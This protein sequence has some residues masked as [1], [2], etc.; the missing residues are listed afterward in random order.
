MDHLKPIQKGRRR[1]LSINSLSE[2]QQSAMNSSLDHLQ[3]DLSRIDIQWNRILSDNTNPLELAL[4]FL[5]DTSVGLGHRYDEFNQLKSQIGSHLQDVVNEH[6]QVFN[7]NV[8]SY[9]KVVGSIM[10]A[11]EQTLNLKKCL[12]EANEKITT[13]KGSLQE[14]NDNNLK[15]TRMVDILVNIE[16]LL[17]I[18]EKIEESIRKENFY[19]VQILLERG[20]ILMNNKSLKTVEILRPINQ[21]L[22][23]QEHLLFN[24]LIEEIHDI[25]YSKSNKTNF[26][27][28]T[29]NDIF[30]IISV[31]HNGFT[32]LENYLYNIV[33]I[34]IM[35]HAKAINKNLEQF[36]HDQSLNKGEVMLQEQIAS[37]QSLASSRTQEDEGFSR[38]GFL[39]TIINNINKLP[40]AFNI[41]T[42]RAKEEIHN[43]IVKSTDSIRL[44]HPS[45]LKMASSL[46]NDN[47]F[48]LPVQDILSIILRECFWEIFLK[49]LYAIQCHRVIFE[50]SNILQPTSSAKP[51]YKFDKIW[52]KLLDEIE[53][54]LVRYINN[55]ELLT[56]SANGSD[57]TMNGTTNKAPNLPKRKNPKIFSLEHNIEDNSSTKD[58]AFELKAL[59]KDI[60]PGFSVS[61]NMDL[62]SIYVKDES[63]EQ[64]EPLV[65]PSIF[66]MKVILDPFLLFTQSTS[67]IV[68][69]LLN[70]SVVPSLTFFHDYVN[71][72]FLPRIQ[73][74]LNYLF[75]IEVESNNPYALESSDENHNIFKTA[76]D[77]QRLFYNLLNVFNTANTFRT[78]ISYCILDLLN[79]FCSYYLGLFNNLIGTSDRHLSRKIITVWFQNSI[80][81]DQEKMILNGDESLFNE[82]SKALFKDIPDFYQAGKG[83]SKSD[84]FNNLTLDTILQFSATVIWILNWLPGLKKAIN[85]GESNQ[86]PMLD[87]DKL[88][89][90]WSFSESMN[91]NV[92]NPNTNP[93]SLGNLKIL[94][95]DKASK[96]F[97]ETVDG[98][99]TLK[100][101]LMTILRFNIRALCI[102]DIGSF[103]QNTKIWN[104]DVGSIE[105]DQNIASLI[106]ELRRTENKLKQQLSEKEKDTV[107]IGLAIINNYALIKGA[108]SIKVLNNNGIKKMLRNVNVLQH[109][110]RNLSSEPSKINMNIAMNFYSLCGSNETELFKYIERNELSYCSID[111]L[112]TILRLQ[113]SEEMQRQLKRQSTNATKGSIKPS[114]KRYTEALEKLNKLEKEQSKSG[115][116]SKIKQLKNSL[117]TDHTTK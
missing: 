71:K 53:L 10:Q 62:D 81:M 19:Q 66:N 73:M 16:E 37:H 99:K 70:E 39:L 93:T 23:L 20:F 12:K 94:L 18:P 17:Q 80:L 100:F 98:F 34:D 65:P 75:T 1:G 58:Q 64:D 22:E 56:S 15:Y 42:E 82:E 77:F 40:I 29:N 69:I 88:R 48:G 4:A 109:A 55:P 89:S 26:T 8:A 2:T 50:M 86:E 74:T 114:N 79:H 115:A 60:F 6:S 51:A 67:T 113:F 104:M 95:D 21:Q 105:L 110:Y 78:K 33:N 47:Q 24:N 117:K 9:G 7:T 13:D 90:N 44:K 61:S 102:Y 63:F 30:K 76:L 116:Y 28:V 52:T 27:Q 108:K 101:K 45:L 46:K 112:K 3:N 11:Q 84:L 14:L 83:L 111:D 107:L 57:K 87:A 96:K 85:V 5:D 43:I 49:L 25:M 106:S 38:I 97:D 91:L 54:L 35:E 31:S 103:F 72:S 68:P 36:I 92:S 59:L 41:I 32:S